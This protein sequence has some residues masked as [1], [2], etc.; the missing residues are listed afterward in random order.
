LSLT[1]L[2]TSGIDFTKLLFG[3]KLF[4]AIFI[5]KFWNNYQP[6]HKFTGNLE[7]KAF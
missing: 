6:R 1:P 4:G 3:Q 5:P 2:P 7:F